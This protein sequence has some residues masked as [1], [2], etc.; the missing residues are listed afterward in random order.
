MHAE[1][2]ET[3]ERI[4]FLNF[5]F[6]SHVVPEYLLR[7]K[8]PPETEEDETKLLLEVEA[9]AAA[10]LKNPKSE[11]SR[12]KVSLGFR[13]QPHPTLPSCSALTLV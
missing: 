5:S 8:P 11:L 6:I 13:L 4:Q 12:L 3:S 7:T 2:G 10:P 9:E 1:R